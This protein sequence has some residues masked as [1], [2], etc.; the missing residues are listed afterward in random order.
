MKNSRDTTNITK[1]ISW[2]ISLL[3]VLIILCNL[4]I[5][6]R[7]IIESSS[8]ES[9]IKDI[10]DAIFLAPEPQISETTVSPKEPTSDYF[11]YVKIPCESIDIKKLKAING[12]TVGFLSISG[13]D[14][15]YPIVQTTDNKFYLK[16]SFKKKLNSS[17]WLFMDYR[18]NAESL[19]RNSI[20]YGHNNHDKTM[21]A[22][23]KEALNEEWLKNQNNGKITFVNLNGITNW[24]IISVYTIPAESYYIK[25][26]FKSDENFANWLREISA[27]SIYDFKY[28]ISSGD[29]IMTFSTCYKDEGNIRLVVHAKKV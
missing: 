27:R 21:L 18:N 13:T 8:I 17:G 29:K 12:D 16:H 10:N 26:D 22:G 7:R 25:T 20:I 23:L 15:N 19:G 9:E 5:L 24:K 14:I 11:S 2:M 3:F 1:F 28:K 4:Y 6:V